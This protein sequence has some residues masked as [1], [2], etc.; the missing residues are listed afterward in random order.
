MWIFKGNPEE[1]KKLRFLRQ[2]YFIKD[3]LDSIELSDSGLAKLLA[4][5][6]QIDI[7]DKPYWAWHDLKKNNYRHIYPSLIQV[8]MC[9]P[10]A[11]KRATQDGEGRIEQVA[12]VSFS[13]FL[14]E[15]K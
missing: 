11:W 7:D 4:Q 12:V 13:Q 9:S 1:I 8:K 6:Q 14:G 5:L 10:D 3:R 2:D 15:G